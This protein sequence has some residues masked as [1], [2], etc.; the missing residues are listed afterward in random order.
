MSSLYDS[1]PSFNVAEGEACRDAALNL[2]RVHRAAIIRDL[3]RAA[4]RLA[5]ERGEITADDVRAVAPIP[6]GIRPVVV[7]A[8]IRDLAD[9]GIIHRVGYRNSTR[10]AA[11]ARPLAVWRLA[12]AA[13][14]LAWLAAHP[15]TP[16]AAAPAVAA[17]PVAAPAVEPLNYAI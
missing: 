10:P 14:A 2:L 8:A 15:P 5:L 1:L 13:A 11:H 3:T 16:A 6:P 7:G 17:P 12:D 9:A 4:V